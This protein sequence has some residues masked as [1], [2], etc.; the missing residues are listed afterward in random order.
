LEDAAE[1]AGVPEDV[2][3]DGGFG[4]LVEGE[5]AFFA[6]DFGDAVEQAVVF[7]RLALVYEAESVE[8]YAERPGSRCR[9]KS[10]LVDGS[11]RARRGRPRWLLSHRPMRR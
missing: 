3:P 6:D 9:G 4:A 10:Y 8:S 1:V 2:A 11:S 7:G 5:R